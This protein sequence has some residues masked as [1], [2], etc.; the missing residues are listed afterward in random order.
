[1]VLK[2][3]AIEF[4]ADQNL[5]IQFG[6]KI[7]FNKQGELVCTE[8]PPQVFVNQVLELFER[9]IPHLRLATDVL[10]TKTVDQNRIVYDGL[11]IKLSNIQGD[12]INY[13]HL[14]EKINVLMV[15]L[16]TKMNRAFSLIEASYV[17]IVKLKYV[18][19]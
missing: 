4:V 9:Y 17:D 6:E 13:N 8:T 15:R 1:M 18:L 10:W 7:R 16:K 19:Y 11:R 12:P 5:T 3:Y 14:K 2:M